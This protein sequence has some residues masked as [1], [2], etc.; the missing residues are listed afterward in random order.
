MRDV[1]GPGGD[2]LEKDGR[3]WPIGRQED[4][5]WIQEGITRDVTITGAIPAVFDA[6][7]SIALCGGTVADRTPTDP[8]SAVLDVLCAYTGAQPWWLGYLDTGASA[9]VFDEAP[10]AKLYWDWGYVVVRAGPEQA[11]AWHR[12]DTWN[13]SLPALIFPADRSWL[14]SLLW[15]DNWVS[16]GG[17]I[18]LITELRRHPRLAS[19]TY[20]RSPSDPDAA[21]AGL[22]D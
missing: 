11:A 4:V 8:D 7:A 14:V 16:V 18:E 5:R 6:Y 3:L 13:W 17:S 1:D 10:R 15:D 9:V 21:P 19:I 20:P 12:E 2:L 22:R